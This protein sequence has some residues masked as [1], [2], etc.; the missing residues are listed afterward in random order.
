M[1]IKRARPNSSSATRSFVPTLSCAIPLLFTL[2][3]ALALA[4]ASTATTPSPA[5]DPSSSSTPTLHV[6]TN[7]KQVPVLV[8]SHDYKRMKPIDQSGFL[9]SLDSGPKFHPTYVR[10]EGDDPIS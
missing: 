10:R 5:A 3:T 8:L 2:S 1:D 4:Q 9:L 7:L 6:Y